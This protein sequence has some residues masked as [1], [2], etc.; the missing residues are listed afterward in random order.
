MLITGLIFDIQRFSVHDGPGIRTTVFFKGCSL[1]CF[2]CH[3]P[4]GLS[5]KIQIQ[6]NIN[7]C[8]QCGACITA[9]AEGA[10]EI[11]DGLHSYDRPLCKQCGNCVETCYAEALLKVGR[12]VTVQDVMDEVLAD[13][14]FYETSGGGVTLSGGE[15]VLQTEF[16][17]ALLTACK[18]QG[19]HT[20]IET[21]GNVRWDS[22]EQLLP[23][24]DL[25]MMDL[26]IID[27]SRHRQFTGVDNTRILENATRLAKSQMPLHFR[28]PV[29]PSVNDSEAEIIEIANFIKGL[30]QG[31]R[32]L[33][34]WELLPFHRLA[35][36]KYRSLGYEYQASELSAPSREQM[37]ILVMT[38]KKS[39][40]PV[41]APGF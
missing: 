17:K 18:T 14:A 40:V 3:N 36:D 1:R 2:W 34:Q 28:T 5:P 6:F 24:I 30:M 32:N 21:A 37:E 35:T 13:R 15:P 39:G 27:P 12:E 29:V 38:A 11:I 16:A 33:I 31:R 26:K 8:I 20:A 25:V 23:E 7:R 4:E 10:H 19:V 9:C 41:C 22:L